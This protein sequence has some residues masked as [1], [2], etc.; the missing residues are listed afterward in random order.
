MHSIAS[1]RQG[2]FTPSFYDG[3]DPARSTRKMRFGV[4]RCTDAGR[5]RTARFRSAGGSR[6][7]FERWFPPGS[8]RPR[9]A[10][11]EEQRLLVPVIAFTDV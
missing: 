6:M 3:K 9:F 10:H 2:G 8:H 1:R 5:S 4:W 11:G 7:I